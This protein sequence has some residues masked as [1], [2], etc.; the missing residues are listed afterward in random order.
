MHIQLYGL[1]ENQSK[2]A[3]SK[4]DGSHFHFPEFNPQQQHFDI[5]APHEINSKKEA[6]SFAIYLLVAAY[7]Y[8]FLEMHSA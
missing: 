2:I 5:G 6:P 4:C 3:R 7:A 8:N 1:I